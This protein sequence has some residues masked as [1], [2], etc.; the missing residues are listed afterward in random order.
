V[1]KKFADDDI[2]TEVRKWLRQLSRDFYAAGFDG[3]VQRWDQS[4]NIG[5]GY[6]EK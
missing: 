4:K 2:E 6:I 3:M 5:G 1:A